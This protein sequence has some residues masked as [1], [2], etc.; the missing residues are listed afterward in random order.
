ME[1]NVKFTL[2]TQLHNWCEQLRRF[3]EVTESDSA[4]LK[5][6]LLD[7]IDHLK[8]AGLDEEE[9]FWVSARR[10]DFNPISSEAYHFI[11]SPAVMQLKR[12]VLIFAG[13]LGF[14]LLY[15]FLLFSSM[16]FF[17]GLTSFHI[18]GDRALG[19][20]SNYLN[21]AQLVL[22]MC[23]TA[24]FFRGKEVIHF[25]GRFRLK[26]GHI[27]LFLV[28]TLLFALGKQYLYPGIREIADHQRAGGQL[29][30]VFFYFRFSFPFLFCL[31]FISLYWKY[32]KKLIRPVEENSRQ[33]IRER[34]ESDN[35]SERISKWCAEQKPVSGSTDSNPEELESS[36]SAL[37]NK[38]REIEL[39]EDE[40]FGVATKRLG[41]GHFHWENKI[42]QVDDW[43][44]QM[45]KSFLIFAGVLVY[46]LFNHFFGITS[47]L[48]FIVLR[49][50]SVD[51]HT[52]VVWISGYLKVVCFVL[53][54]FSINIYFLEKEAISFLKSLEVKLKS[55]HLFF[56]FFIVLGFVLADVCLMAVSKSLIAPDAIILAD[57]IQVF[58]NFDYTFP[59]II[60]SSCI[61]LYFRYYRKA[62]FKWD[63]HI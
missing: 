12:T 42:Q 43:P 26:P 19:W 20:I 46:F 9:A 48:L 18:A 40:A 27:I 10:L 59:L 14:F 45:K 31:S 52:S 7:S 50:T 2:E 63:G 25:V 35:L 62:K 47:K 28:A 36:M 16:L 32:R 30:D 3:P 23:F 56:L 13:I 53:V 5:S 60:C 54:L 55:R 15:Y 51:I 6:H 41:T 8:E 37:V 24:I 11:N 34:D 58:R 33:E 49:T 61:V 39:D 44:V 4:E 22:V 38:L 17:Y 57:F 29:Y 21:G 1:R